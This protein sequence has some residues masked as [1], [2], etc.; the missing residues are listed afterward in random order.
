[1]KLVSLA[2]NLTVMVAAALPGAGVHAQQYPAK[3]V[4][5][6]V[7]FAPGGSLDAG[8]RIIAA[9]MADAFGQP[10]VVENRAGAGGV[11]GSNY[12]AKAAPDGY[13]IL[14]GASSISMGPALFRKLPYD[15][16]RD[17]I[18]VTQTV[19]TTLVLAAHPKVG[20]AT[21]NQLVAQAKV[22]PGKLTFGSAGVADPLQLGME[23]LMSTSG[24]EMRAIPY[25]GQAPM[26]TALLSGEIDAA[27]ISLGSAL[28]PMRNGSLKV[29]ALTN[30][31]RSDTLPDVPTVSESIPG[32]EM[33]SW[34]GLFVPAGT[35]AAIVARIQR[36]AALAVQLPEVR[37]RIRATGSEVVGNSPEQFDAFFKSEVAKITKIVQQARIPMQD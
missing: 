21:V 4:H 15:T 20:V 29:L 34:H 28:A 30:A 13:T 10:V 32:V 25:K 5:M 8:A 9:K 36:E 27:I 31:R 23:L 2:V 17:F 14:Y 6:V 19:S 24:T 33:S 7:P 37:D 11:I 35:P 3:A 26:F 12:V 16:M 18:P 1:M 22:N